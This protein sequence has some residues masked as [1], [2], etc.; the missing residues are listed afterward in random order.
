MS[1]T[2]YALEVSREGR[3]WIIYVPELDQHTQASRLSEVETMGRD[4]VAVMR[5]VEPDAFDVDVRISGPEAAIA[6]WREAERLE[7]VAREQSNEAAR[8]RRSAVQALRGEHI[9]ADDS[10]TLLGISRAR[11]YQLL[12]KES[13]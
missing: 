10:A 1:R 12:E 7:A 3:W 13:A 2:T 9:S 6:N 11:V 4:L 5:D 8:V